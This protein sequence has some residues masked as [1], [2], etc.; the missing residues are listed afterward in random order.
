MELGP[1]FQGGTFYELLTVDGTA[2]GS[3][4]IQVT[5]ILATTNTTINGAIIVENGGVWNASGPT[6]AGSGVV[7]IENGG[8]L[9]LTA[10]FS[11]EGPLTNAGTINMTNASIAIYNND[12]AT[13]NG[14]IDNKGQINFYG[15]GGDQISSNLGLEYMMNEGAINEEAGTGPSAVNGYFG[16]L[17]GTYNAAAG[18]TVQFTGGSA[19]APLMVGAP[20][21]LNG[22]GKYQL[23]SGYTVLTLD[24]VPNLDIDRR[25]A[26]LGAVVST[27]RFNYESN[28]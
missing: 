14:G 21:T 27:R 11:L 13:Y 25:G 24:S 1:T 20:P 26:E 8:T 4:N 3:T 19:I 6:L 17:Q 28:T 18:T 15:A 7:M 23:V 10:R 2:L 22:P 5:G 12:T 9:N 16:V